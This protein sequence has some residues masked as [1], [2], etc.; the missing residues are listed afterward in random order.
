MSMKTRVVSALL[1]NIPICIVLSFLSCWLGMRNANVPQEVFARVYL[2]SAL[3]SCVISYV[4][5]CA[6]GILLP[7]PKWG[8]AVAG[9]LGLTPRDGLKFGLVMT[10]FINLV[11]VLI[12]SAVLTYVNVIV[13]NG[14][15]IQVFPG[16][17]LSSLLPCY[18]VSFI[19]SFL[20]AHR[21]E[22]IARGICH[23]AR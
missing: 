2:V 22:E 4:V 20:W 12:L 19:I 13:I 7:L 18:I 15:P 14:A 23:D 6:V 21:A 1:T 5:G 10:A 11:Y 16:A 9:R 8:M 3:R 17:Y